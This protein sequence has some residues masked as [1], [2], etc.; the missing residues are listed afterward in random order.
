MPNSN[1]AASSEQERTAPQSDLFS[2]PLYPTGQPK[3]AYTEA[4]RLVAAGRSVLAVTQ[5]KLPAASVL[6]KDEKTGKPTW[7]PFQAHLPTEGDLSRMFANGYYPARINGA[8][9]GNAE[10][11]DFDEPGLCDRFEAACDDH[12]LGDLVRSLPRVQTPSGG[13]H[14]DY[15]CAEPVDG[16]KKLAERWGEVPAGTENA[17]QRDGKWIKRETLIETRGEGGYAVAP[18][19]T[20]YRLLRGDLADLPVITAAQR[21]ALHRIA[22]VLFN[23][24]VDEAEVVDA[25][26]RASAARSASTSRLLPGE[27]YNR[28]ADLYTIEE[29]LSQA[30]WQCVGQDGIKKF[31]RRPGKT[32]GWSATTGYAD[33]AL[34][35]VF[36]T[37][38]TPFEP[39][40]A[41][42][43]FATYT[44]LKHDGDFQAAAR[45]LA[46]E[47]Y[48]SRQRAACETAA[49]DPTG[50]EEAS[51]LT[52][53][54]PSVAKALADLPV[55][56]TAKGLCIDPAASLKDRERIGRR[57][58][59]LNSDTNVW[60]RFALGDW[61]CSLPG[62][63]GV[64]KRKTIEMF[65]DSGLYQQLKRNG[66]VAG[67]WPLHRRQEGLPWSFYEETASFT[68]SEQDTYLKRWR[69][70]GLTI[71]KIREEKAASRKYH[72]SQRRAAAKPA[73][74]SSKAD[75]SKKRHSRWS[76][77]LKDLE[78]KYGPDYVDRLLQQAST[79]PE[80]DGSDNK[81][82]VNI[83][84]EPFEEQ[85]GSDVRTIFQEN[86]LPEPILLTV[87]PTQR[88]HAHL[89]A[90]GRQKGKKTRKP[91]GDLG[92]PEANYEAD[93]WGALAEIAVKHWM[94]TNGLRPQWKLLTDYYAPEPDCLLGNTR[95]EIKTSPP[96]K[97]YLCINQ[98]Q[99]DDPA[100]Q[101]DFY[102]PILFQDEDTLLVCAP[103]PHEEVSSWEV[104]RGHSAYYRFCRDRLQPLT[105]LEVLQNTEEAQASELLRFYA[106]L[107]L[108]ARNGPWLWPREEINPN[109][110]QP[111]IFNPRTAVQMAAMDLEAII[112]GQGDSRLL[113][114]A[115]RDL[116]VVADWQQQRCAEEEAA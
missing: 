113:P 91:D 24:V 73:E 38:A 67:H 59:S 17:R 98:K 7:K 39:D 37:N 25:A 68:V 22:H 100:R 10:T 90:Q 53:V 78:A 16:N 84:S 6:P 97:P 107:I 80:E 115:E 82:Y 50:D 44:F 60:F 66:Y 106:A 52:G 36:S 4:C 14:L 27:D 33:K 114:R 99:H 64:K 56:V 49:S 95:Y 28:Q 20:G 9:S 45:A 79:E 87:T 2:S 75:P 13:D 89:V 61:W 70:G 69:A 94:E 40:Q 3:P 86:Q 41:Y 18:P 103:I 62:D 116:R 21:T 96:G 81:D 8:V 35:Y 101:C 76:A 46:V 110:E 109:D 30:G 54:L 92:T 32:K 108:L 83:V 77:I 34:L 1:R 11:L 74:T 58:V 31:W 102:L 71:E 42:S 63:Y 19:T 104:A 88:E 48:G 26:P 72:P 85:D 29:L 5:D 111:L 93:L 51:D 12:G 55:T 23:E 65:G 105:S 47:G 112:A 43:P 57:L 15:R